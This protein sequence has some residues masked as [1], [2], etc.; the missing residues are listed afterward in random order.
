[1]AELGREGTSARLGISSHH[2]PCSK[3]S[4]EI[5]VGCPSDHQVEGV[6]W[7][8]GSLFIFLELPFHY[9]P[10]LPLLL[11]CLAG[12]RAGL[13]SIWTL[14]TQKSHPIRAPGVHLTWPTSMSL[15]LGPGMGLWRGKDT[16]AHSS[17]TKQGLPSTSALSDNFLSSSGPLFFCHSTF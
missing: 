8:S 1:M 14:S 17:Y 16:F 13:G 2:G 5:H 7:R 12:H 11:L 3:V 4:T 9:P 15:G 10:P 6:E